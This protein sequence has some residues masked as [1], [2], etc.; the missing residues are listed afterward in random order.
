MTDE[1]AVQ[2]AHMPSTRPA[3]W[4]GSWRRVRVGGVRRK[5]HA[6]APGISVSQSPAGTFMLP[7]WPGADTVPRI[8][9]TP[10]RDTGPAGLLFRV[11]P[12]PLRRVPGQKT[13]SIGTLQH[14]AG[15]AYALHDMGQKG[16]GPRHSVS[17]DP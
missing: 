13:A 16:A 10:F 3:G 11:E 14:W 1:S 7:H 17:G 15:H 4:E 5:F 12:L 9:N 2:S 6:T 8:D